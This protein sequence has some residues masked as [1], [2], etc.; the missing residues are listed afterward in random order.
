MAL[1]DARLG[2]PVGDCRSIRGGAPR[3]PRRTSA[4]G[5]ERRP[6]LEERISCVRVVSAA[7]SGGS[8]RSAVRLFTGG[9]VFSEGHRR[10]HGPTGDGGVLRIGEPPARGRSSL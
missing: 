4:G 1:A 6:S 7:L 8:C 9:A 5:D 3:A 10:S 2:G